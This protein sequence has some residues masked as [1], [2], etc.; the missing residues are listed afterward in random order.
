MLLI[1]ENIDIRFKEALNSANVFTL[2]AEIL[3]L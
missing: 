3:F 1:D 2:F